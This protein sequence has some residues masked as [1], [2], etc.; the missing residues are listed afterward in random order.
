MDEENKI[1]L[2]ND[3]GM[4][5]VW[6]WRNKYVNSLG[7]EHTSV[8]KLPDLCLVHSPTVAQYSNKYVLNLATHPLGKEIEAIADLAG[9]DPECSDTCTLDFTIPAEWWDETQSISVNAALEGRAVI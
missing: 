2:V 7:V 6:L 1:K 5:R 3:D 4:M 8:P 9:P